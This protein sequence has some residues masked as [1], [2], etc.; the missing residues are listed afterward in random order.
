MTTSSRILHPGLR[1]K[2]MSAD[3]AATLIHHGDN[4]G[5]SGFTGAGYPKSVPPALARRIEH[6]NQG[7]RRIASRFRW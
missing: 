4:V 3:E 7:G 5:M 1:R 6:G 2:I